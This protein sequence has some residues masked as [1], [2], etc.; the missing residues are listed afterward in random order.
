MEQTISPN[1]NSAA[2][3]QSAANLDQVIYN[4]MTAMREQAQQQRNQLLNTK[5]TATGQETSAEDRKSTRLNSSHTDI[6]R[7]PSSA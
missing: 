2:T 1:T 5:Q 3:E 4:K 7:M 6:S